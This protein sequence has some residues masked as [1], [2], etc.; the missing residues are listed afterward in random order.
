VIHASVVVDTTASVVVV[1]ADVGDDEAGTVPCVVL[2]DTTAV[3]TFTKLIVVFSVTLLTS[4]V[5]TLDNVVCVST[6]VFS[7]VVGNVV[8]DGVV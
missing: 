1:C 5:E 6:V 3:V 8:V 7:V 4:V 2:L